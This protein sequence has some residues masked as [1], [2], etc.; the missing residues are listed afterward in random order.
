MLDF[1]LLLV[2]A[3]CV[4]GCSELLISYWPNWAGKLWTWQP[5]NPHEI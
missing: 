1:F 5:C 2:G 3:T 4:Q